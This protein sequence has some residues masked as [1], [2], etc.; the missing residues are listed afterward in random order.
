ML[1]TTLWTIFSALGSSRTGVRYVTDT[2]PE[3]PTRLTVTRSPTVPRA[4]SV[5]VVTA[6][7][8]AREPAAAW[9]SLTYCSA[10]AAVATE[11]GSTHGAAVLGYVLAAGIGGPADPAAA[12]RIYRGAAEEGCSEAQLGLGVLLATATEPAPA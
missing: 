12:E 7:W 11:A 4:T 8:T 6:S 2:R 9:K 1:S 3:S 5:S 10:W